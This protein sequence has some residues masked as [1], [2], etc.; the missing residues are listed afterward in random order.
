MVFSLLSDISNNSFKRLY[1][2]GLLHAPAA[3]K[4][5]AVRPRAYA[6]FVHK[7]I[8]AERKISG[9]KKFGAALSSLHIVS[10]LELVYTAACVNELLL[11]GK[12]RVALIADIHP[13]R[14]DV[15]GGTR[16]KGFAAGAYNR[17]FVILGMYIGPHFI[18]LALDFNA[19]P[20]Y[21]ILRGQSIKKAVIRKK[22]LFAAKKIIF[23]APRQKTAIIDFCVRRQ[24]ARR[25]NITH[26]LVAQSKINEYNEGTVMDN[27]ILKSANV[28]SNE[29]QQEL[30]VAPDEVKV[31]VAYVLASNFDAVLYS[32][33]GGARYPKTIGRFA[34]GRVT[35]AG[36]ECYGVERNTRVLLQPT[37]PCGKCL[38]CK[39][40]REDECSSPAIAGR[41]FDGFLRDFVVC[42]YTEVSPIPD[43][44]TDIEALCT[45]AV[46]LAESVYDKLDLPAGSRVAVIGCNFAGNIIAQVLQ[47][48][49][50]IPI[51]IDSSAPALEKARACGIYY[52]F[53]ADD[54]LTENLNEA[55]SGRLCDASVYT[56]CSRLDPAL[57]MRVLA[58][59]K[60][61]VLAGFAPI[62]FNVPARELCDKNATLTTVMTGYGYTDTALNILVHDAI[63]TD[64]FEKEILTD[65]DPNAVYKTLSDINTARK[66][67]M[68]IF[69]L[70]L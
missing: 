6:V 59:G 49:K 64:V 46:A 60:C 54:D 14:V 69:K 66:G 52:S 68:T 70:I 18:H 37:R 4:M 45:E 32:G 61:A 8:P 62:N 67:K 1:A 2:A 44:V 3:V 16:F 34:V 27:W 42:K 40:G 23:C 53:A 7:N 51:V 10:F 29:Q 35:E 30:T 25:T 38:S 17:N 21:L 36:A 24:R 20:L 31:K 13:E 63:N 11:T 56:T 19:K 58:E 28:L 41:D 15:L 9:A 22:Y 55:T 50:L 26:N 47:Y 65:F 57:T 33:D 5:Y 12:E 39:T 48:H 43:S